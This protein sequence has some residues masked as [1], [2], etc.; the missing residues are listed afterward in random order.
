MNSLNAV[1]WHPFSLKEGTESRYL[2]ILRKAIYIFLLYNMV[3]MALPNA[4]I[5]W[6]EDSLMRS[7]DWEGSLLFK[8]QYLMMN[9][10]L[11]NC[12]IFIIAIHLGALILG[13]IKGGNRWIHLVIFLTTLWLYGRLY[14]FVIGGNLLV[15][16]L[17][18][19]LI[20]ADE[21]SSNNL[22]SDINKWV[23]FAC[24]IQICFVYFFSGLYKLAGEDK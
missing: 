12:Y 17:L 13:L 7:W 8:I 20:F 21:S 1:I 22:Q 19:Y 23:L 5:Y 6:G 24:Q 15:Q 2:N 14:L 4:S 16:M 10:W 11:N 3:V 9:D 18:F